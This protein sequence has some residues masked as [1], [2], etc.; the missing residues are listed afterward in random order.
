MTAALE[1]L[2]FDFDG[3]ILDTETPQFH[4]V[5]AAFSAHGV[6][7]DLTDWQDIVGTADHP[8]WSE[9]L[10]DALGARAHDV[11]LDVVRQ[12]RQSEYHRRLE[13]ESVLPGVV[14]LIGAALAAGLALAVASSSPRDWVHGHLTRL[15]LR[16]HFDSLHTREDVERTKPAPDLFD[17]AVTSLGAEP[18]RTV[19]LEDSPHG[20]T[21]AKAAG[22]IVVACPNDVTRGQSFAHADLVVDSLA[23]VELDD[24]AALLP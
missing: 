11:D 12:E 7:L 10:A 18:G 22:T 4:T 13:D 1:A 24:L 15:G 16:A 21:A 9:M 3:L 8:H 19:V 2:V 17:R 5:A 6:D 23:A 14:D 20:V